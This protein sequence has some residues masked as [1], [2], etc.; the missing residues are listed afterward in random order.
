MMVI[1]KVNEDD[2]E[3]IGGDYGD[4]NAFVEVVGG[5]NCS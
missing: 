4:A 3:N 1:V 5:G 2:D